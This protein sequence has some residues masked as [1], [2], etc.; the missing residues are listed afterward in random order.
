MRN[1][2]DSSPHFQRTQC[3]CFFFA[4]H[5]SE[6]KTF[7]VFQTIFFYP[8]FLASLHILPNSITPPSPPNHPYFQTPPSVIIS[9]LSPL[10]AL[11]LFLL[12]LPPPFLTSYLISVHFCSP[13]PPN[14]IPSPFPF[15]SPLSVSVKWE[16]WPHYGASVLQSGGG[17]GGEGR[18]SRRRSGWE[19]GLRSVRLNGMINEHRLQ[20][21]LSLLWTSR[22]TNGSPL[23]SGTRLWYTHGAHRGWNAVQT[24][25]HTHTS[26]THHRWHYH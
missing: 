22:D 23:V 26:Q 10:I 21:V 6:G 7:T 4:Q 13:P 12:F 25:A 18:R 24:D 9:F 1:S 14:S 2:K 11:P 8:S 16:Q 3:F 19:D 15:L 20:R 17:R 5:Q